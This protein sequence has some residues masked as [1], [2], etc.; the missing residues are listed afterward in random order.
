MGAGITHIKLL[1]KHRQQIC[2][3][4]R[5]TG[6]LD[7]FEVTKSRMKEHSP[8]KHKMNNI[9]PNPGA[10]THQASATN[11]TPS[12]GSTAMDGMSRRRKYF[13]DIIIEYLALNICWAAGLFIEMAFVFIDHVRA[14][15]ETSHEEYEPLHLDDRSDIVLSWLH[16]TRAHQQPL[17]SLVIQSGIIVTGSQ[18]TIGHNKHHSQE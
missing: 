5:L 15:S 10:R 8:N 17:T 1:S 14:N 6:L 9:C 3:V 16:C 2:V 12:K 7:F 11:L 4:A 18:V 13:S